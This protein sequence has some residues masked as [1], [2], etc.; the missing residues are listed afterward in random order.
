MGGYIGQFKIMPAGR[1]V[2]FSLLVSNRVTAE[3]QRRPRSTHKG[4]KHAHI[5]KAHNEPPPPF[6]HFTTTDLTAR[7]T[8]SKHPKQKH[9]NPIQTTQQQRKGAF[10]ERRRRWLVPCPGVFY[11]RPKSGKCLASRWSPARPF[12]RFVPGKGG[13]AQGRSRTEHINKPRMPGVF[14]SYHGACRRLPLL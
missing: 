14:I 11:R 9:D 7:A 2:E 13:S 8:S 3:C 6:R 12:G 10:N 1:S 5:A 4:D